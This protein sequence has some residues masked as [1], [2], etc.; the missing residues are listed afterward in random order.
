[1]SSISRRRSSVDKTECRRVRLGR[2]CGARGVPRLVFVETLG[3]SSVVLTS[4]LW[5]RPLYHDL[6]YQLLA[7]VDQISR[8]VLDIETEKK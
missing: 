6:V 4:L 3:F 2:G 7:Y 1:M 5:I 8:V